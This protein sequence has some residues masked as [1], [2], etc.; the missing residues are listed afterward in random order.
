MNW[1]PRVYKT[2]NRDDPKNTPNTNQNCIDKLTR[3]TDNIHVRK[4]ILK[5]IQNILHTLGHHIH[6]HGIPSE[7]RKPHVQ[8]PPCNCTPYALQP[9][10]SAGA[11]MQIRS[12]RKSQHPENW[13]LVILFGDFLYQNFVIHH[14]KIH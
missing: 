2:Q 11:V 4:L 14:I 10:K 6:P 8:I 7:A 9:G 3:N 13:L 1:E 12:T 5:E